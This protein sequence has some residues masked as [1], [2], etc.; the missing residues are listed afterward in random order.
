MEHSEKLLFFVCDIPNL[1]LFQLNYDSFGSGDRQAKDLIPLNMNVIMDN[2]KKL[3]YSLSA[4][5]HQVS[6]SASGN[7]VWIWA[8]AT[9]VFSNER[10][11]HQPAA[12]EEWGQHQDQG[13][14]WE[15]WRQS[16]SRTFYVFCIKSCQNIL[17]DMVMRPTS[18]HSVNL[19]LESYASVVFTGDER[20][21]ETWAG[22][23]AG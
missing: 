2:F 20:G 5:V 9:W 17:V 16:S 22:H 19:F 10:W 12:S 7:F 23:L 18:C 6:F 15:A 11:S 8:K 21:L 1:I 3:F 4:K 14:S 13:H